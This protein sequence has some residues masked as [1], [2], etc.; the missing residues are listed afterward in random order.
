[1]FLFGLSI[2]LIA[3]EKQIDTEADTEKIKNMIKKYDE[4]YTSGNVDEC[5]AQ[6]T[7]D[8]I[9]MPPNSS[10]MIGE[11]AIREYFES[12][13][14]QMDTELKSE[15][16]EIIICGDWAIAR[17]TYLGTSAPKSREDKT[18]DAGK[19]IN[20]YKQQADG[21]WKSHRNIWNSNLPV[22]K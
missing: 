11:N 5:L 21:S 18:Q 7:K 15:I 16:D 2:F 14:N 12:R 10:V 20:I 8:A 3:C 4:A 13:F 9:R 1:M 6:F 19:W 22:K 17:G